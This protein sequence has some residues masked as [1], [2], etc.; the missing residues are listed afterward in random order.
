[1]IGTLLI[2]HPLSHHLTL[3][4]GVSPEV[5]H[6]E[7]R[8]SHSISQHLSRDEDKNPKKP[9]RQA[10]VWTNVF[11]AIMLSDQLKCRSCINM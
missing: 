8:N 1:M 7:H 2:Q 6:P 10:P 11:K 9:K 4:T 3:V 5:R